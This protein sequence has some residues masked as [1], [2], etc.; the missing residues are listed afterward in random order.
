M[1]LHIILPLIKKQKEKPL[2]FPL[3]FQHL[4]LKAVL[5]LMKDIF[6]H[7]HLEPKNKSDS[8]K[9]LNLLLKKVQRVK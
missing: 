2:F 4:T 9:V 3:V 1:N 5:C 8:L 7:N 6:K